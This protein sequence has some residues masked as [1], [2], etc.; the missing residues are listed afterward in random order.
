MISPFMPT[1]N[2]KSVLEAN[3]KYHDIH[4]KEY[5]KKI[6]KGNF[7]RIIPIFRNFSGGRFLDLG[8]GMGSQLKIAKKYF[9]EI[10]GIDCSSEMLKLAEKITPNVFLGDI[11]EAPFQSNYFDFINCFSVFHH[12]YSQKPII[13]EAY[14]LLKKDGVFYSDNDPSQKFYKLFKWWLLIRRFFKKKDPLRDIAEYH[15]KNGF[16]PEQLKKE[17]KKVGFELVAIEY[18]YPE[19]PDLF[20]KIIMFLNRFFKSNSFYYYF[21]IVA[22]K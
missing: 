10:Y 14:R 5:D 20:T 2:Y 7:K 9:D 19:N 11:S 4:A 12:C 17:F 3:I 16:D 1:N 22:K 6:M 8:C 15:Q 21:S 13:K 18:H